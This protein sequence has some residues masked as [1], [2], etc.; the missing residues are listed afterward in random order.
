MSG[1]KNRARHFSILRSGEQKQTFFAMLNSLLN[2]LTTVT[3]CQTFVIQQVMC[4]G[5]VQ[6]GRSLQTVLCAKRSAM[7]ALRGLTSTL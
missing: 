2:V 7:R 4:D 5:N 1:D 3:T 6:N